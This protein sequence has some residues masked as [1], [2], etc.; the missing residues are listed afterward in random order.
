MESFRETISKKL[1][2]QREKITDSSIKT[3]SSMLSSLNKKLD[4]EKNLEFFSKDHERI[5]KFIKNEISSNQSQKTLLSAL[6]ILTDLK[7]YKELMLDICKKV[8]DT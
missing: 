1:R 7:E 3:Y 4:G 6:Y 8:N 5:I 2:E